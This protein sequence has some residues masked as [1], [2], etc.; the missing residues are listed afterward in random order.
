MKLLALFIFL[1]LLGSDAT[2]Q[3]TTSPQYEPV[4]HESFKAGEDLSYTVK[5]GFVKGGEARFYVTDTIIN[6]QQANHIVV[7]GRTTGIADLIFK[8]RDSYE[9]YVDKDS[10]LSLMSKRNIREGKYKYNDIITYNQDSM[11]VHKWVKKRDKPVV[12]KD[13]TDLPANILDVIGA[14]YHARNNAFSG[15]QSGDTIRYTTFFSNE[16]Y[17]LDLRYNGLETV[18]T[19]WGNKKCHKISPITEV[20]RS[21]KTNEDMH[22]WFTADQNRV[23]VKIQFD[24]TVG[25][26]VCELT[27]A[28]GLK[29]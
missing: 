19:I 24:L 16:L 15:L 18:N 9:S 2:A 27:E 1:M 3:K 10:Q 4:E 7:G 20:G 14:F 28:E 21:F 11:S 29:Y 12:E 25:S 17:T 23:P 5:Y 13:E 8:V 22:I 6:G 26:F